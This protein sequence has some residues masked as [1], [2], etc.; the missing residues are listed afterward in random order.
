MAPPLTEGQ[1]TFGDG[2][3]ATVEQMAHDVTTFLAWASE[4]EME[5]RKELGFKVLFYVLI[6]TIVLY[7]SKRR[8]WRDVH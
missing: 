3:K 1:V 4:P 8:I 7:L 5:S 2:A 6:M